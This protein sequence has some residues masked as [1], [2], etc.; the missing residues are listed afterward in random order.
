ML[1]GIMVSLDTTREIKS[2]TATNQ[3]KNFQPNSM[4]ASKLHW[5]ERAKKPINCLIKQES[6]WLKLWTVAIN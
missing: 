5:Q 3:T 6:S 4:K 1:D 2:M